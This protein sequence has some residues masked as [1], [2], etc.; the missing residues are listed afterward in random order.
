MSELKYDTLSFQEAFA[1]WEH[2]MKRLSECSNVSVKISGLVMFDHK[3]TKQSL[4]PFVLK[5][6]EL[7]GVERC[8]FASNF[9]VD[10]VCCSSWQTLMYTYLDIVQEAR[11][12]SDHIRQLFQLNAQRFYRL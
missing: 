4:A 3:W 12:S 10:K 6:I 11:F 1:L 5:T 2:E 7:F 9:P 8:M